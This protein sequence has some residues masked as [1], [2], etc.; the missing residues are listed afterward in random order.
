MHAR[1]M[2]INSITLHKDLEGIK[3]EL[4]KKWG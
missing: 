1:K 2:V 3:R 4:E